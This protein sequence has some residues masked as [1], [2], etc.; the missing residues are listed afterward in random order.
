MSGFYKKLTDR[1]IGLLTPEEQNRI[2]ESKIAICGLGGVGSPIAEMLARLGIE[3]FNVLDHGRFEPTNSNRQI[4]SFT[5]SDGRMKTEVTK[6]YLL[7]I[8]PNARIE[9]FTELTE[10]NVSAF[11]DQVD[12]IILAVDALLP[13][14][15]LSRKAEELG[16]PLIEGWA[17][18]FGNVRVFTKDTIS[19][20]EAYG[21]PTTGRRLGDISEDEQLELLRKSVFQVAAA[22]PGM[23]DYYPE[24]AHRR[25]AE[26]G[27]GTTLAP[28]VWLSCC[29]MAIEAYKILVGK[30][31]L[32]LAPEWLV[33]DPFKLELAR[34][35]MDAQE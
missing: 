4:Y 21:F 30:G 18:A 2:K 29:L 19:L 28:F 35:E 24:L 16:L 31:Q 27:E 13:I 14:L 32:V 22:F 6:E 12:L 33:F 3:Q 7:K 11:C 1:N 17:L 34:A 10:R 26:K 25:L 9:C 8:N 23:M 15:L 20:E 5:D